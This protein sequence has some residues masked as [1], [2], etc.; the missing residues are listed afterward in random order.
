MTQKL[1]I[2][3]TTCARCAVVISQM[4]SGRPRKYCYGS[5]NPK[6]PKIRKPKSGRREWVR[7]QKLARG[8]CADCGWGITVDNARVFDWD[9]REPSLKLFELS[10]IP[11]GTSLEMIIEEMNKCDVVCRNCHGLRPT[12]HMGTVV[13][14]TQEQP[15]LGLFSL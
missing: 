12:S 14:Q 5:C 13:R 1:T 7:N 2:W 3:H 6:A 8:E 9:H 10:Q 4:G 11:G 15:I